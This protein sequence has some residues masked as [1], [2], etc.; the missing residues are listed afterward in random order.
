MEISIW[1]CRRTKSALR[2]LRLPFNSSKGTETTLVKF[3]N[4]T[5]NWAGREGSLPLLTGEST[6][7]SPSPRL[8]PRRR[9]RHRRPLLLLF[10]PPPRLLPSKSPLSPLLHQCLYLHHL[11]HLVGGQVAPILTW[12]RREIYCRIT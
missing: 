9:H 10:T 2:I 11:T 12:R 1:A 5:C 8:R 4:S 6:T 7:S 3:L